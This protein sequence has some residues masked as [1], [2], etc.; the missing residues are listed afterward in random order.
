MQELITMLTQRLGVNAQQAQGGAAILFKAAKEKL[1]SDEFK[2][3]LGT[4]PGIESLIGQAPAATAGGLL[5]GLAS[6]AGG[7]MAILANVVSGFLK[8]NLTA[9]D[10]QRFI[11]VVLDFLHN[12]VGPDVVATLEKT[13]RA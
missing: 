11:P 2:R 4:V 5:G 6:L 10:A 7:N 8:L 3:L 9:D 13:L 12:K 1:G